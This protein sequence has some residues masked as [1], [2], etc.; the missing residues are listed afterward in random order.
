MSTATLTDNFEL[1]VPDEVRETMRLTAGEQ[2]HVI[3]YAGF[4]AGLTGLELFSEIVK[5]M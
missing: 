3:P 5:A 2:F 1:R 4:P